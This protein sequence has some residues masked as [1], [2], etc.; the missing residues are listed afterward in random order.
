MRRALGGSPGA[1]ALL[2]LEPLGGTGR[3]ASTAAPAAQPGARGS[4]LPVDGR[5]A[6]LDGT[7]IAGATVRDPGAEGLRAGGRW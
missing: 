7:P 3:L 6:F 5:L 1:P 4:P 2:T